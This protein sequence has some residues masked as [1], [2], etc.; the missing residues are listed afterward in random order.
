MVVRYI[1]AHFCN[2]SEL[3]RPLRRCFTL[4]PEDFVYGKRSFGNETGAADGM[5]DFSPC[6]PG[7]FHSK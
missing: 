4:P 5:N 7:F 1:T 6:F 3:G 2:Q